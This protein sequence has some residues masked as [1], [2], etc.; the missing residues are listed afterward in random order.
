MPD[1]FV[2]NLDYNVEVRHLENLFELNCDSFVSAKVIM[3]E[4]RDQNKGFGFVTIDNPEEIEELKER[5]NGYILL[6][7]PI[8]IKDAH[9]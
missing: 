7:K 8:R 6:G 5:L 4:E 1:L 3:D 9:R 2:G